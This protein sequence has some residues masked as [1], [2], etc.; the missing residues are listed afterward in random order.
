VAVTAATA[1][2]GTSTIAAA[3]AHRAQRAAG[4]V[5]LAEITPARPRLSGWAGMPLP[6]V[7]RSI[8]NADS[9]GS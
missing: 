9:G 7:F 4:T 6:C 3:L 2:E 5:L 8:V 1:G